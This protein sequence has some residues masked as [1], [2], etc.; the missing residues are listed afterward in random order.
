MNL[1]EF[2]REVTLREGG[3]VRL[4]IAQVKEV[5]RITLRML[6][7]MPEREV[8]RIFSYYRRGR[9][10]LGKKRTG[11]FKRRAK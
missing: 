5:L 11:R 7:F 2:A 1:N 4:S 8:E 3:K 6:A 9:R 10:V